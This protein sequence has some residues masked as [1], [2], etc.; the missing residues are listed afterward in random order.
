[1]IE[2]I[3]I[4]RFKSIERT[5]ISLGRVTALVG[6]NN[7]GKSSVLQAF[8][9]GVSVAQSLKLDG[10]S[11]WSD[12]VL[13]GTLSTQ[14]LVYTP[15]RDVQALARGGRL[16]QARESAIV[17]GFSDSNLGGTKVVV[18]RGKNKNIGVRVEGR[19][20]GERIQN[21]QAP[22]SVVAPG[23]A[24]IPS[25]EE[26]KSAGLVTRAAAR[27]DANSVFRNILL[28]L[29]DDASGWAVF[30]ERLAEIFPG[31][32]IAVTF[33]ADTDEHIA[34]DVRLPDG[35]TLP[36]DSCGTGV[37]QAIQV[38]AYVGVYSPQ[39]LILDEP[40]SHLH[41]DNQRRL[42]KLLHEL[43]DSEGTQVLLSTHSRH[44]VDEMGR[45]SSVVH[46]LGKGAVV[47][48]DTIAA[49]GLMEL[50]ALDVWDRLQGG[51][52][53]TVILTEDSNL[54]RL[55]LLAQAS[56]HAPGTYEIWSYTSS[57][58]IDS[59]ILLGS[60]IRQHAPGTKVVVHRDRDYLS[61]DE[62][63]T[64]E[65][66][67]SK[68]GLFPF[69]TQGTDVES[70]FLNLDYLARK[71]PEIKRE[72][73]EALRGEAQA[74]VNDASKTIMINARNEA[75]N[76][77]RNRGE[78]VPSAAEM[79]LKAQEDHDTN[80]DR[81]THGKKWLKKFNALVQERHRLNRSSDSVD[82]CLAVPA[83][84]APTLP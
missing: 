49:S 39:L 26:F 33:N 76:R 37:L 54:D 52:I 42:V 32:D 62:V 19:S 41:P 70:H 30:K 78:V 58:R 38:L 80:P 11:R 22:Y 34:I 46:W 82:S 51:A 6:P 60:F 84:A 4:E 2:S 59:A 66:G 14:Q 56:G 21:L 20:L 5:Q 77:A 74:A 68:A 23:L 61:D 67:L 17:I 8:Q 7:A 43:A 72:D 64:Y 40:D 57:S 18:T 27:G 55:R 13:S 79:M 73:L 53:A 71:Y 81:F 65:S 45:Y 48:E 36:I 10:T 12:D 3:S 25:F 44:I 24:G 83:L 16:V 15:L 35:A 9:F 63:A 1:M 69:V 31:L 50:G 29:H 28:R 75:A 47:N